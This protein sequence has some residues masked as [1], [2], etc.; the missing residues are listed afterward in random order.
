[1]YDNKYTFSEYRNVR[2]YSDPSFTTR[3]DRLLS[4]YHWLNH[5]RNF[6][7]WIVKQKLKRK[8]CIKMLPIYVV[9][10]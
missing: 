5:F 4:F 3:Y 9:N 1:M 2:K 7:P 6:A 8:V 10:C